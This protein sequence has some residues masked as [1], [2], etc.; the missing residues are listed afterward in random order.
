MATSTFNITIAAGKPLTI[1]GETANINYFLN[2]NLVPAQ[3][4]GVT[5]HTSTVGS[6]TRQSY[7][8][9]TTPTTVAGFTRTFSKDGSLRSGSALPGKNFVLKEDSVDGTGE[10]RTFS[11][12]GRVMDLKV[13]LRSQASMNFTVALN[14]GAKYTIT[15]ATPTP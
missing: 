5:N 15:A 3:D 8:G 10:L 6:F 7:P 14:T 4:S 11:F 1:Y 12:K 13:F 9:D 2:T